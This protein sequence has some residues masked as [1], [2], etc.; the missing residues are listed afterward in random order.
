MSRRYLCAPPS[1][2]SSE[3]VFS[4]VGNIWNDKR[5]SLGGENTEKLCFLHDNLPTIEWQY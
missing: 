2:V 3:R 1:S 5:S 4:T